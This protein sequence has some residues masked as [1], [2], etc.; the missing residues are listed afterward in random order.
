MNNEN[1]LD[2]MYGMAKSASLESRHLEPGEVV[3]QEGYG[4]DKRDIDQ[5]AEDAI[6]EYLSSKP[7]E[8]NF[9]VALKPEDAAWGED[10]WLTPSGETL[11][12]DELEEVDYAL[13]VDQ[14][15]GTKNYDNKDRYTTLA[16]LDPENP[17]LDGV[18]AS[19]AYRWDD[20]VFFSD[21]ETAYQTEARQN[22]IEDAEVLRSGEMNEVNYDT[23]IRGQM[24]GRNAGFYADLMDNII[25]RYELEENDWPSLKADGTTTGDILGAVTDNSIA[26]DVRA[27]QDRGRLPFAQDFAPAAKIAEDAGVRVM[28]EN[29]E[30]IQT[31]FSAEGAATAYIAVP[32]G[33]VSEEIE[34]LVKETLEER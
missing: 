28:D 13:V 30:P 1:L 8:Y 18:Q 19:I 2:L 4:D 31:D 27:L 23:K 33:E 5:V 12:G 24:I 34:S 32:E 10:A 14:V 29:S 3:S 17:T 15:E 20:Q 22:N 6:V 25:D 21:G 7:E 16:A 9:E 11:S 26:V